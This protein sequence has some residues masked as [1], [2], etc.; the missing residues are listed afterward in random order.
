MVE[1]AEEKEFAMLAE[2]RDFMLRSVG[3]EEVGGV[4]ERKEEGGKEWKEEKKEKGAE[5]VTKRGEE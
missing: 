1:A 5:G 4:M 2:E 3:P